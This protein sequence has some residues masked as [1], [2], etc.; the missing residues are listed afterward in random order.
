MNGYDYLAEQI[1]KCLK[2]VR[3]LNIIGTYLVYFKQKYKWQ[4]DF[5]SGA[6]VVEIDK[7]NIFTYEYDFWEGQQEVILTGIT[8]T[9]EVDAIPF[10]KVN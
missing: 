7:N 8:P 3:R 4:Q 5:I 10:Y 2:E 9:D 6:V 1:L